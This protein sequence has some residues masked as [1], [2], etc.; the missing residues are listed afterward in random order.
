MSAETNVCGG[1]LQVCSTD[2]MTGYERTGKCKYTRHDGGKH[3]VC[4]R[5]TDDFLEYTKAQGNGLTTPSGGFAGL[6]ADDRW[7]IC[8]ARYAQA[9]RDGKA[10]ILVPEATHMR[11]RDWIGNACWPAFA[12]AESIRCVNARQRDST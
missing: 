6:K 8:A 3:L 7:C 2:P 10:P 5:M 12:K 4:A 1:E 11:A 9:A